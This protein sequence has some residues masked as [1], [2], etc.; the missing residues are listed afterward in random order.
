MK[1]NTSRGQYGTSICKVMY[2]FPNK[3]SQVARNLLKEKVKCAELT[4]FKNHVL[5]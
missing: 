5:A 3:W 1:V 2:V 4:S